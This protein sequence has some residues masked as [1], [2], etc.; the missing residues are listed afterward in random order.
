MPA[1]AMRTICASAIRQSSATAPDD[2]ETVAAVEEMLG[3]HRPAPMAETAAGLG[4]WQASLSP[5][6]PAPSAA[7]PTEPA[8]GSPDAGRKDA[9]TGKPSDR[10]PA[11][12][13]EVRKG[14]SPPAP[15]S[16]LTN[17]GGALVSTESTSS[18]PPIAPLFGGVTRSAILT[19]AL[20]TETPEGDLDLEWRCHIAVRRAREVYALRIF[21]PPR[22]PRATWSSPR[23]VARGEI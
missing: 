9:A 22:R 1:S 23:R 6:T 4:P 3:L 2:S 8:R 20:S 12:L 17:S 19:A 14:S 18:P 7:A 21:K 5:P 13:T 15:P 10:L 16:W 11:I